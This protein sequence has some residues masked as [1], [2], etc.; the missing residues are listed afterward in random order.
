MKGSRGKNIEGTLSA[1]VKTGGAIAAL[2]R[3]PNPGSVQNPVR[4]SPIKDRL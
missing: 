3:F 4:N 2:P 1:A